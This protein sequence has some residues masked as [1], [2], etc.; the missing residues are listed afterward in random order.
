M[1]QIFTKSED[2]FQ[3]S[4]DSATL[5]ISCNRY[6][7]RQDYDSYNAKYVNIM[8]EVQEFYAE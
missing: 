7:N 1:T 5:R 4:R 6:L 2:D 3:V 8:L